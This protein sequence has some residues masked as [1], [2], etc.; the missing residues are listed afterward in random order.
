MPFEETTEKLPTIRYKTEGKAFPIGFKVYY[1]DSSI[2]TVKGNEREMRN[3]LR[4]VSKKEDV[5]II[6]IYE[7]TKDSLNRPTRVKIAGRD[8]YFYDSDFGVISATDNI[9]EIKANSKQTQLNGRWMDDKAWEE[10]VKRA[11]DDYE[12]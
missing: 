9:E 10:L 8:Y 11:M 4:N 3:G 12:I 2:I 1:G 5:Q 7:N 6:M